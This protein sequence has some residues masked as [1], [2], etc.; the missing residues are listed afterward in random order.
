MNKK[1]IRV[2]KNILNE[3]DDYDEIVKKCKEKGL[4]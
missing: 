2:V 1:E 3:T 4:L